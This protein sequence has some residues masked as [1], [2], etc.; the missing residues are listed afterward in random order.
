[1]ETTAYI[2]GSL[3]QHGHN[4]DRI[5]L[6]QLNTQ[7]THGLIEILDDMAL[8]KGYGKIFGKIPA[9]EWDAF[10]SAKYTKEAVVPGFFNGKADCYFIAKYF[11]TKRKSVPNGKKQLNLIRQYRKKASPN[12]NHNIKSKRN[13]FLCTPTDAVE[14]S[15]IYQKVFKTYPFP[16]ERPS[17]LKRLMK[18]GVCYYGIRQDR[19]IAALAA[20]EIDFKYENVEMTD[21]A[22]LPKW[23][24]V[25]LAS[26]LLSHM[27]RKT[28]ELGIKTAY[29]MARLASEGINLVFQKNGYTFAGILKNNTQISGNIQSMTVWYKHL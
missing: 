8:E 12:T 16:I 4:N 11:S 3:I 21:F 9:P 28:K 15:G 19:R 7:E 23:R 2:K 13:L 1:M 24:S 6:M 29:A 25:G 27:E 22:T 26:I 5:Y 20:T 10:E 18:E 17:Y 14:M